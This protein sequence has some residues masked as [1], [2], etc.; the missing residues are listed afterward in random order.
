MKTQKLSIIALTV[1]ML[2]FV[3]SNLFAQRGMGNNQDDRP[4]RNN[5]EFCQNIPDL[6]PEQDAKI[7]ELRVDLLKKVNDLQNQLNELRAKK[8]TLMTTDKADLNAINS[9][10]DQMTSI[11]NKL[12]KERAK[13][14]QDVRS[15]LTEE[16]KVIFD[17][18]PGRGN[19]GN[20]GMR[21]G[22]GDGYCKNQ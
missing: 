5:H 8:H 12:M 2:L 6:T 1:A 9:I 3:N 14:H 20:H 15:L 21:G 10:I 4:G 19:R 17:S 7:K 13:H 16:Q 18:R 11:Q 22:R